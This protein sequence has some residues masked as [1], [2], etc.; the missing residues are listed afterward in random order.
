MNP[1]FMTVLLIVGLGIFGRTMYKKIM[2]LMALEPTNRFNNILERIK[3]VFI[4]AIG[5]KR[6][7]GRK[8]SSHQVLCTRFIFWGFCVLSSGA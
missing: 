2:L 4:I 7:V 3:N 5:Q 1:L 8:K 6:L